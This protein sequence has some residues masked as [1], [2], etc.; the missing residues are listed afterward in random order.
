VDGYVVQSGA[1][2]VDDAAGQ[3]LR[4]LGGT[5]LEDAQGPWVLSRTMA[6]ELISENVDGATVNVLSTKVG[7]DA[8]ETLLPGGRLT[9]V[10]D[11]TPWFAALDGSVDGALPGP[12]VAAWP[13][14]GCRTARGPARPRWVRQRRFRRAR[15]D[16]GVIHRSRDHGLVRLVR[17]SLGTPQSGADRP[18]RERMLTPVS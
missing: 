15:R 6:N 11:G 17:G 10:D 14:G 7:A 3:E 8:R 16:D 12:V 2:R 9:F 18:E 1:L 13:H 5:F 4:Q